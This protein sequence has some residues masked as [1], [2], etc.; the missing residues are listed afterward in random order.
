MLLSE[1]MNSDITANSFLLYYEVLRCYDKCK[2][3]TKNITESGMIAY[4]LTLFAGLL[5][6]AETW[7]FLVLIIVNDM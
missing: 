2:I 6:E 7:M 4:A 3:L 5:N 1:G